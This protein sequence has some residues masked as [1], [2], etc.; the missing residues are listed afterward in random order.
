MHQFDINFKTKW[1]NSLTR[2]FVAIPIPVPCE[3]PPKR[4][5]KNWSFPLRISSVNVTKSAVPADLVTF[6]EEILNG[7]LHFLCSEKTL[8]YGKYKTFMESHYLLS[9][10]KVRVFFEKYMEKKHLCHHD[11]NYCYFC[12]SNIPAINLIVVSR[13][14]IELSKNMSL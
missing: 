14:M 12:K 2:F 11:R 1:W 4:L 9:D 8:K 3:S 5:H 13:N 7:K 10:I 6:T